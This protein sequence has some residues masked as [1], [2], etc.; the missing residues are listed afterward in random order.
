MD[1][2]EEDGGRKRKMLVIRIILVLGPPRMLTNGLLYVTVLPVLNIVSISFCPIALV[3][4]SVLASRVSDIIFIT[5]VYTCLHIY[6][7]NAIL[8]LSQT[9]PGFYVSAVQV[10]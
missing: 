1:G 6:I 5:T 4:L 9:S 8:S 3:L 10:F 7:Q 2:V